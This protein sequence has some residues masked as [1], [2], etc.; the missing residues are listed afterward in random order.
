[1]RQRLTILAT[2]L[3]T[4]GLA[5]L[6]VPSPG[7]DTQTREVLETIAANESAW[8]RE[9]LYRK[10]L[11]RVRAAAQMPQTRSVVHHNPERIR[12]LVIGDSFTFGTGLVDL[13]TR[14]PDVLEEVLDARTAPGTFEVVRY[15][16]GGT[17]TYAHASWAYLIAN[18]KH[19][20]DDDGVALNKELSGPFD[21]L[22]LGYVDNDR[23]VYPGTEARQQAL[24]P[25]GLIRRFAEIGSPNVDLYGLVPVDGETVSKILYEGEPDPNEELFA[26]SIKFMRESMPGTDMIWMALSWL[27]R[28]RKA[29]MRSRPLFEQSGFIMAS[30]T[31][32]DRMTDSYDVSELMVTGVDH[33][34]GSALLHAYAEDAADTILSNISKKRIET[35]KRSARPATVPLVA[36]YAPTAVDVV[37]YETEARISFDS[38]K[39]DADTCKEDGVVEGGVGEVALVCE[40]GKASYVRDWAGSWPEKEIDYAKRSAAQVA[41]CVTLNNPHAMISLHRRVT[42]TVLTITDRRDNGPALALYALGYDADG[43]EVV[44]H[45]RDISPGEEVRTATG[46]DLRAL[47]IS[48]SGTAAGCAVSSTPPPSFSFEL[49]IGD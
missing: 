2:L 32:L 1:M 23:F 14:W 16:E 43:F 49:R 15:A 44:A 21:I 29:A 34:P 33:H 39:A 9:D 12:V 35:A 47:L 4:L 48:R 45:I 7:A 41:P 46:P 10:T 38:S 31:H 20:R 24:F 28:N 25:E 5:A 19:P 36:Y 27:D 30:T 22:I 26:A 18:G 6:V 40:D 37:S 11:N 42:H 3:I 17:S 13:S 8:S